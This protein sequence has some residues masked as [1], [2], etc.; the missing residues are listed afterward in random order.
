MQVWAAD[1]VAIW[2]PTPSPGYVAMGCLATCSAAEPPPLKSVVCVHEEAVTEARLGE[3]IASSGDGNLW[4]LQ[5][6]V[7]TFEVSPPRAHVPQVRTST[8]MLTCTSLLADGLY[9]RF[10]L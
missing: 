2:R 9:A 5:N 3:C 6:D 8:S 4:S 1:G 7:G 10:H